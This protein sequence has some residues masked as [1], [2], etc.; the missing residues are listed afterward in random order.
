M[1]A[2]T[3]L[4]SLLKMALIEKHV[5]GVHRQKN[6]SKACMIVAVLFPTFRSRYWQDVATEKGKKYLQ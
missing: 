3:E 5:G 2:L 1:L 6:M 4:T